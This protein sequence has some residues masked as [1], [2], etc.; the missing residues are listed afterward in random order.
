MAKRG[1]NDSRERIHAALSVTPDCL[2]DVQ[3]EA[4]LHEL[5]RSAAAAE[6]LHTCLR[7]L[8]ELRLLRAFEDQAP[9]PGEG[10]AV[11]WI[12]A[13]LRDKDFSAS[14][15]AVSVSG[16]GLWRKLFGRLP[17]MG[18]A[19]A[20]IAALMVALGVYEAS[21]NLEPG[22]HVPVG[23]GSTYRSSEVRLLQPVGDVSRVPESL[24]W[25]PFGKARKYA[26]KVSEV[27]GSVLWS[28]QSFDNSLTLPAEL[29]SKIKTRKPILWQVE[30]LDSS[31]KV[32]ATSPT[33]R[34][35]VISDLA[36]SSN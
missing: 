23:T 17:K 32:V 5:P 7:C 2:S 18:Y 34:F 14:P 1:T 24:H 16:V 31:D 28:G 9:V 36:N 4:L 20:T 12:A 21:K 25:E 27:D 8:T 11:G 33:I 26:I 29:K 19:F 30:A 13:Q 15:S 10:A 35:R 6:H 3:L 22:L